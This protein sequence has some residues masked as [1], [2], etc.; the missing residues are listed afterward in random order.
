MVA[1]FLFLEIMDLSDWRNEIDGIDADVLRLLERR[2]AVVSKIGRLKARRN[3]PLIDEERERQIFNR[4]KINAGSALSIEAA[5]CIF[6]CIIEESRRI[7]IE[8][9]TENAQENS[10]S[11]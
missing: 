8:T 7:Q 2:A 5:T 11:R 4:I 9:R 6:Q 3:L 10:N 1:A